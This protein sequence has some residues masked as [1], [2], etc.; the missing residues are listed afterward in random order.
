MILSKVGAVSL[1]MITN[2]ALTQVIEGNVNHNSF[3]D[4]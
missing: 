1:M 4:Y 2:A 3:S